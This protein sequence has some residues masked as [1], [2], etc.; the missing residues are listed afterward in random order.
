[1]A[2]PHSGTFTSACGVL[3]YD[4]EALA[5]AHRGNAF[6]CE[7]AQ[8]LV[9]RQVLYPAGATFRSEPFDSGKEFLASSDVWFRPVFLGNGPDGA[10]YVA[11]MY[12]RE[13]DHPAYVPEESRAK[14]D[15]RSGKTAGRIYRIVRKDFHEGRDGRSNLG[16]GSPEEQVG[17]LESTNTWWREAALRLLLERG[18]LDVVKPLERL[19]VQSEL[20]PTRVRAL[21]ILHN[22]H[23]LSAAMIGESLRDRD[24]G[25]REQAVILAGEKIADEPG[26][27]DGVLVAARDADARVRFECALVL[28]DQPDPRATKALAGVALRDGADRW[29]RA[30]VLSGIG[31]RMES[32]LAELEGARHPDAAAYAAVMKDLGRMFGAGAPLDACRSFL[33][34]CLRESGRINEWMPPV[35]GLGEGIRS[36]PGF[37]GNLDDGVLVALLG[38]DAKT[39]RALSGFFSE[40]ALLASTEKAPLSERLNAAALIGYSSFDKAGTI[41][42]GLLDARNPR[43]LQ[44][45]AVRALENFA[46]TRAGELL[47]QSA[48][49]EHYTP[50][51]REAVIASLVSRRAMIPVLYSAIDRGTIKPVEIAPVQRNRLLKDKDDAIRT[52]AEKAFREL[53]GGD[54]MKVY[55]QYHGVLELPSDAHRGAAVFGR[56]CSACHTFD[57]AGGHVGPDLSGNRNQPADALLLHIL[58][59]NYE[60]YPGYQAVSISTHDGRILSGRILTE[61]DSSLTLRTAFGTDEVVMR[62]SIVSLTASSLSLMPDGLEQSMS[63]N[64]LADLIAFL[65]SP[66]SDSR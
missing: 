64:E 33:A 49:W 44:L 17:L 28:G 50:Q 7:P 31:N 61:T 36:R 37:G 45:Q 46:D 22:L 42:G 21:W 59:P 5:P 30:A 27:L 39:K 51:L 34:G 3:I 19:A 8:N 58:V 32:F 13:I 15:F 62:G 55:E 48:N 47:I 57:G 25:V 18:K 63:R 52:G 20:P 4:G 56:V 26:L 14:F 9:Q 1:M 66:P 60:V 2:T 23:A 10:L 24:A 53:Q 6:I 65:K 29:A 43:E 38:D 12:R 35:L 41:L 54:R 40:A 16:L 11:D